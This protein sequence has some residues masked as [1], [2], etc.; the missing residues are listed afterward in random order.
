ML[1]VEG[2]TQY[3]P[4]G[5]LMPPVQI[6]VM[7][8]WI[9]VGDYDNIFS[10]QKLATKG[11]TVESRSLQAIIDDRDVFKPSEWG[12]GKA[13][14]RRPR[15]PLKAEGLW[16]EDKYKAV[17]AANPE[18]NYIEVSAL[19]GRWDAAPEDVKATYEAKAAAALAEHAPKLAEWKANVAAEAQQN[20]AACLD[21]N[22]GKVVDL[23][24]FGVDEYDTLQD[25]CCMGLRFC[26]PAV[27]QTNLIKSI[28]FDAHVTPS[29]VK[30]L[31]GGDDYGQSGE[32]A[33]ALFHVDSSGKACFSASEAQAASALRTSPP[34]G[35][36]S[37]SR[38]ACS[39]RSLCS[40]S[41]RATSPRTF[42]T[43]ACAH[44]SSK[45][46]SLPVTSPYSHLCPRHRAV[47]GKLN[48]LR[49][50][51]IVRLDAGAGAAA[52]SG[53]LAAFDAWPAPDKKNPKLNFRDFDDGFY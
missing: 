8:A 36:T 16:F 14:M 45:R 47:Y 6:P 37:A 7:P 21:G 17:Q 9:S 29:K 30:V 5:D 39:A 41:S 18:M 4:E 38:L 35:S 34:C 26:L 24:Q 27:D 1:F 13:G 49:V 31:P 10:Y 42:A 2:V 46:A 23:E 33:P 25:G 40:R 32:A 11:I 48:F 53:E 43:S 22:T 44:S 20:A 51:G 28:L 3:A 19:M 15:E 12:G 52:T 50:S